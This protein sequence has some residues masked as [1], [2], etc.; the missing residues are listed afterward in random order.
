MI[1]FGPRYSSLL[2][3]DSAS[4]LRRAGLD[5]ANARK[6]DDDIILQQLTA[7]ASNTTRLKYPRGPDRP[8]SCDI[9]LS[10]DMPGWKYAFALSKDEVKAATPP[11]TVRLVGTVYTRSLNRPTVIHNRNPSNVSN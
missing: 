9:A 11:G 2:Q 5:P 8:D 3:T 4:R 7:A 1:I 10:N 6:E